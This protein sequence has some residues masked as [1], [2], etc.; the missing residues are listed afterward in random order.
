MSLYMIAV[1]L[2][3]VL[4]VQVR[5]KELIGKVAQR[6]K[7]LREAKGLTQEQ[8]YNDLEIHVGRIE[9]MKVNPTVS[10][11]NRLCKYFEISLAEF[12]EDF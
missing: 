11:I 3:F 1:F 5:D 8:L 6:V 9:S 12:F 4:M 2:T 10:T 7:G